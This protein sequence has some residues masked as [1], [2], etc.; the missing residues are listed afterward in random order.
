MR[1]LGN[2]AP[3]GDRPLRAFYRRPRPRW[4]GRRRPRTTGEPLFNRIRTMSRRKLFAVLATLVLASAAVVPA[5]RADSPP[6]PAP[7]Y[8][9]YYSSS[10]RI[11]QVGRGMWTCEG[12]YVQIWGTTSLYYTT[13]PIDCT[14]PV[15]PV[16][17]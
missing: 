15:E 8:R 10:S 1:L 17:P 9:N 2:R 4:C 5:V 11:T 13:Q 7:H 16:E 6:V 14:D 3:R 12:K